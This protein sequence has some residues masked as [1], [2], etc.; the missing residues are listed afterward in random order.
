MEKDVSIRDEFKE[1]QYLLDD[2]S[3]KEEL[4]G[5]K[6]YASK[7][8]VSKPKVSV[9]IANYNNEPY[10]A[11]MMDSLM[12]Q[13]LGI[14]NIQ[15]MFIDDRSTDNSLAVVKPYAERYPNVEIYHLSKNTGGAHGPRN[16]GLLNA[17]G[18]YLVFLDADDWYALDGLEM[19]ANLLDKSGD[20]IAFGGIMRSTN[21]ELFRGDPSYI[22][23]D[24]M[25]R[26]IEDLPYD[27]Y[28]W[29]GPQANMV[30]ASIVYGNN[31]HF[32]NQRVAD[33]VTFFLQVLRFSKTVSQT[34]A[35]ITYLNRDDDNMSL[36]KS[37]NETFMISWLR[38]LSYLKNTYAMDTSMEK[39]M[40]RRLEWLVLDFAL[41]WDTGYGFNKEKV[42]H[43]ADM[44]QKYLGELSFDPVDYFKTNARKIVWQALQTRDFDF[45]V[46]FYEWYSLPF[47]DKRLELIDDHYYYVPDN[48]DLPKVEVN[49]RIEGSDVLV[50]DQ[51]IIL[52]F[53][54]YT[55]EH[56][57]FC[58]L[59]S[60]HNPW[61]SRTVPIQHLEGTHYQVAISR[62]FYEEL[63]YD[64]YEVFI[65]SNNYHDNPILINQVEQLTDKDTVIRN[66]NNSV[67][68]ERIKVDTG[69]YLIT[70]ELTGDLIDSSKAFAIGEVVTVVD[71]SFLTGG[72]YAFLLENGDRLTID[73]KYTQK[74]P[75]YVNN[76]MVKR[77][78]KEYHLKT[79]Y[80]RVLDAV[81]IYKSPELLKNDK[82]DFGYVKDQVV[83]SDRIVFSEKLLP[84]LGV[85]GDKFIS[86]SIDGVMPVTI[87]QEEDYIFDL[88]AYYV[89][90]R[91][92]PVYE[93]P[94]F[95]SSVTKVLN[96]R[97]ILIVEM[98]LMTDDNRFML[99][100]GENQYI[101]GI[102]SNIQKYDELPDDEYYHIGKN[103]IVVAD[104]LPVYT[105]EEM[106][107]EI[108]TD[109]V[110][111]KGTLLVA[112]SFDISSSGDY[113]I[114]IAKDRYV[115]AKKA[116]VTLLN[117]E[118]NISSYCVRSGKYLVMS[119][120][121]KGYRSP[122][123]GNRFK[124]RTYK[125]E[126]VLNAVGFAISE[127]GYP[128]L[129]L[130]DGNYVT[131]N[132][133]YIKFKGE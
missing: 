75:A 13:T 40:A 29:L 91:E 73:L 34:K 60:L 43:F 70:K 110:L 114:A 128:R 42:A 86:A 21:G 115:S 84:A 56:M 66:I 10:L 52:D 20:G 14:N 118:L 46:R 77:L 104:E 32:I 85:E 124:S 39:F 133:K 59:R 100:I 11:R 126:T 3:W 74:L 22:E 120:Q 105:S 99:Q 72:E 111:A 44:I 8:T 92:L 17:R 130:D 122:N 117:D 25:N 51:Q 113:S 61:D 68:I 37:V 38:A 76:E 94:S 16:V 82:F 7:I 27:F 97:D 54:I 50:D 55:N 49:T 116:G 2:V 31:L 58:E 19:L 12:N 109:V 65:R 125:K 9:I 88:G 45:L 23:L 98:V 87:Q 123:F 108:K 78:S 28:S 48:A 1:Y 63:D 96:Y 127:K 119:K 62:E 90:V 95:S 132:Q 35:L 57:N 93:T 101:S 64:A 112:T 18:E 102:R 41:R 89:I 71:S 67:A 81:D 30:R 47:F 121:E 4:P 36:S 129:K 6:L 5:F 131:S 107:D 53:N 103:F 15:V 106:T 83:L 80:L 79:G 24:T 26:S 33:D 69:N